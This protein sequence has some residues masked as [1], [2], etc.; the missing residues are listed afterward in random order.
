MN[1]PIPSRL[2][3]WVRTR[4]ASGQ[5]ASASDYLHDLIRR[6]QESADERRALVAALIEGEQSGIS[7]LR[8][9]DILEALRNEQRGTGA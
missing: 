7:A 2:Q 1:I 5:Y 9:P 4:V 6:D 3:E 8:V